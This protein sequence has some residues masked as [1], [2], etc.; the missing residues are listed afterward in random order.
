MLSALNQ[1]TD[2]NF[3]RRQTLPNNRTIDHYHGIT[4][5]SQLS[6]S[7]S[8][9]PFQRRLK[10]GKLTLPSIVQDPNVN[11]DNDEERLA[12]LAALRYVSTDSM[13][14]VFYVLV[15]TPRLQCA[16]GPHTS[17]P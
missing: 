3:I 16:S 9:T 2:D 1:A 10:T 8:S 4:S 13:P 14:I 5:V 11:I 6:P 17:S 15:L 12:L 7:A